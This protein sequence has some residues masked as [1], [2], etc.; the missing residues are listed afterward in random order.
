M[1]VAPGSRLGSYEVVGLLAAGGMGE[2]YRAHH[3]ALGRDVALKVLPVAVSHDPDRVARFEREARAVAALSHPNILAIHDFG[4]EQGVY[5]AVTELLDGQTLRDVLRNGPL[6]VPRAI[7]IA[8]QL[9]RGLEA[10]HARGIVHRDLKPENVFVLNDGHVKILDFGLAKSYGPADERDDRAT[11]VVADATGVGAVLGTAGYM[12]PEQVRGEAV[13]P[14]ADIFAFGCVLYE[15]LTGRRAFAGDSSIDTLHATLHDDPP[16]LTALG[17]V[18]EMLARIVSRSLEKQPAKR[19]QSVA[20]LRFALETLDSAS[21][22]L[23]SASQPARREVPA[24]RIAVAA[25]AIAVAAG[26]WWYWRGAPAGSPPAV[27]P[28]LARGVAVLPF[29]NLGAADQAYF[30][31]GVTEEVTVQLAKISSLRVIGR[32]ATSRY[33]TPAAQLPDMVRELA[34]GAVLTGSVRQSGSQLRVTVQLLAAPYGETM[35]SGQYD[36]TVSNS[37]DVQSDIALRVARAL[38]ASLAPEERKRIERAPT[39]NPEAYALYTQQQRFSFGAQEQNQQGIDLLGK[40]I[41]LDPQFALAY[42]MLA[43]RLVISGTVTGRADFVRA[44]QAAEIAVQLDP[45]LSRAHHAKGMALNRVGR[46]DEARLAMQR[47]IEVDGN[48]TSPMSDLS[49]YETTAGRLDHGLYWAMRMWPLVPNIPNS[50]Y[51]VAIPLI[52]LD[53]AVAER[54]LAAAAARFKPDDPAG[55][56][57]IPRMQAIVAMFRNDWVR[58]VALARESVRARPAVTSSHHMLAEMA[59]YAG[60]ADADALVDKELERGPEGRGVLSGITP[61]TLRA[62]LDIRAGRLER[63]RPML[64]KVLEIN[65]AA[66]D[67]GD[68]RSWFETAAA[69]AL[70]GNREAAVDA[71][72]HVIA[73]GFPND[74]VDVYHPFFVSIK[75]HPRFVAAMDRLRRDVAAMRSRV[76]L[77]LIDEWIARGAPVGASR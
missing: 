57:R 65:R 48:A 10:A 54:W 3:R 12:A 1:S 73:Q 35:W 42:A 55:G 51:H 64:E 33:H 9:A 37:F 46:I 11:T 29:E 39:E 52:F 47:A 70:L 72:E 49:L 41:A 19:F 24:S 4:R 71:W 2:V 13:D 61:R 26:G 60:T 5:Y 58:A 40:S 74:A 20:D 16:D 44:L 25:I 53:N 43:Q 15:M 32:T 68:R 31:A 17:A 6:P 66:Q 77:T 27:A 56:E 23:A 38:Q 22:Q 7:A 30:A 28:P 34:I 18:P 76:D 63:A 67:D 8:T 45:F 59:T 62:Y 14:R 75:D 21:E 69:L 50:Y 36:R